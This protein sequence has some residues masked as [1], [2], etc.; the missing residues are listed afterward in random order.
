M[1]IK[2]LSKAAY[3]KRGYGQVE[4]QMLSAQRTGQIYAQLPAN[5]DIE[6]LENGQFVK[7]DYVNKEVNFT[8]KGE[9]MLVFNEVKLYKD[10]Q[11]Y[12]DFAMVKQD[13]NARVYS[14][15]GQNSSELKT[16][17][18]YEGEA[19]REGS[20]EAF[21]IAIPAFNYPQDMPEGTKMVPRVIKTNVGDLYTTNCVNEKEL[22][23]G[24][25]LMVGADGY[26][27]KSGDAEGPVFAVVKVYTLA[28]NQPAVKLQRIA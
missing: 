9:W 13:Y 7:Y 25:E 28:D 18:N 4:P 24:D 22:A 1:A 10:R 5:Q 23:V 6:V 2:S 19:Y 17:M 26:L 3:V 11:Q 8:G 12:E 16:V 27:A 21:S 15:I 20:S 14:P